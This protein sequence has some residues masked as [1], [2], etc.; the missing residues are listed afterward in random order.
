MIDKNYLHR[1][2]KLVGISILICAIKSLV[3]EILSSVSTASARVFGSVCDFVGLCVTGGFIG[4]L[5]TQR[6]FC[7]IP[8]TVID[9]ILILSIGAAINRQILIHQ[10]MTSD[11]D[12][13]ADTPEERC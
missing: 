13:P 1:V 8:N 10:V 5:P 9:A 3:G 12:G 2:H 11:K 4:K 7:S 6:S